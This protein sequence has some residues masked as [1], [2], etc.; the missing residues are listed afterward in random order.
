MN[1]VVIYTSPVCFYCT[2]AKKLLTSKGISFEEIDVSTDDTIR[3]TMIEKAMGRR[4]VPQIFIHDQPIG[5]C[6][7][8]YALEKSGDLERLLER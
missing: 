2:K 3:E 1:K 6:D 7:D 5:G 4:T 8:L